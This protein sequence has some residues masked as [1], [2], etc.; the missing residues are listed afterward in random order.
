MA[1]TTNIPQHVTLPTNGQTI[2]K[3]PGKSCNTAGPGQ[4]FGECSGHSQMNSLVG[5]GVTINQNIATANPT[6][7][8][9]A[10]QFTVDLDSSGTDFASTPS[11]VTLSDNLGPTAAL[12]AMYT[13][14]SQANSTVSGLTNQGVTASGTNLSLIH[15]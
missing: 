15:I 5:Q 10:S 4:G 13:S 2:I 9:D 3:V 6:I 7:T 1:V 8:R 11:N 12:T 14:I